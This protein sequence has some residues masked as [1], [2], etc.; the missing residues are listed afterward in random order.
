MMSLELF[1][2]YHLK[3]MSLSA[4]LFLSCSILQFT[5]YAIST[6]YQRKAGFVILNSQVYYISTLLI[7]LST[8]LLL[9]EDLLVVNSLTSNNFIVNDFFSFASKFVICLTSVL[10]LVI[11]NVS[12][13]DEP[14]QN[15]FEYVVLIIISILGLLLLC[16]AN[17]LIT[18]YLAIE[19]HS[20]AF[21]IMAAFKR[22]SSYSI[23]SGLKY[24]IIGALS[25]ALF[26]F[27]SSIIYGCTGSLS[28]DD[29]QMFLS[30]MFTSSAQSNSIN[31]IPVVSD[32]SIHELALG[33]YDLAYDKS[34]LGLIGISFIS[35]DSAMTHSIVMSTGDNLV[36]WCNINKFSDL[37]FS[38]SSFD[39]SS[40]GLTEWFSLST[41]AK[42]SWFLPQL[43]FDSLMEEPSFL[44]SNEKI[45]LN[46][47]QSDVN[48]FSENLSLL[49]H[50][51][52]SY[53]NIEVSDKI[54]GLSMLN[55]NFI[56]I[57][58]MLICVSLFIKLSIAPFHLWS[59][60]VYEGSPNVTTFFFTV[61]PKMALFVLLMRICYISFYQIFVTNFQIYFFLL[62]V[63][64]VFVGSL[65][66]LEQRKL[67]TLLAYSSISHTGYLL[68]SF[69]TANLEGVQMMFYYLII[70]M[71]SGLAFWAVYLFL[72]QK[73][74]LYFNKSN[75]ELG[76]LMLLNESN[77]MLAFIL[78]ITLFSIAG[79]PP[80]VGFL[81][82]VGI[83]LVV[84]K[85]S[86]YLIAVL[87]ILFSVISTF[88]Y[89]RLVKILYFE[90]I[91][92]GKLYI[93]ITTQKALLISILALS[94][95][96]LCIDPMLAYLL[97]YK[98][99]LLI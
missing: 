63:L 19:L 47:L 62:A 67:K 96:V 81:A 95:I 41:L 88:Y 69:S 97:F 15:N 16:S 27:G 36:D 5:F 61:I 70:Y 78:A 17:D 98:A 53:G 83:F 29:L 35:V 34:L 79:I 99:V 72:R 68:L 10:F 56:L 2:I 28:F 30:L 1:Q 65:G 43:I 90:N 91:L 18:A 6:A 57:G 60:D 33:S 55:T 94:L 32:S 54:N 73:R 58:F 14:I 39:S 80:I 74:S 51:L 59:L 71:V 42:D 87:S 66:G 93:P 86:A 25:S 77:P 49:K 48:I 8:F 75:K 4:E 52:A 38:F 40:I 9:N 84:V 26:L 3:E 20:I 7:I 82:K 21:Y 23:E 24:F 89:I 37:P 92:V 64:S 85:S 22:K 13:R 12:F 76:D 11:V 46:L 31:L 50:I 44:F 45:F